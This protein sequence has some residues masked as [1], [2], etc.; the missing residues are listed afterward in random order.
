[1]DKAV[2]KRIKEIGYNGCRNC[3]NVEAMGAY[4]GFA[5]SGK[6]EPMTETCESCIWNDDGL[7][8]MK[9]YLVGD[10]TPACKLYN[11]N[12]KETDK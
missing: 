8:D 6:G 9:G 11:Q 10:N 2:K 1:M 3:A 4:I 5:R 7:C 12:P